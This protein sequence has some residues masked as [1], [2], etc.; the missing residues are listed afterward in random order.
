MHIVRKQFDAYHDGVLTEAETAVY[1]QH[2]STCEECQTWTNVQGGIAHQLRNEASLSKRLSPAATARI[3]Q[4]I[5]RR[6]RRALIMNNIRTFVSAT[7]AIALL[8]IVTGYFIWQ[9]RNLNTVETEV[10]LS[11]DSV[12]VEPP[13]LLTSVPPTVAPTEDTPTNTPLVAEISTEVT[14]TETPLPQPT[15]MRITVKTFED[16]QYG[17]TQIQVLDV[18]QPQ[19]DES[20]PVLFLIQGW[21][22]PDWRMVDSASYYSRQ[23]YNVVIYSRGIGAYPQNEQD[24]FCALAWIHANADTYGFDAERIV[25]IGTLTGGTLAA[26]IATVDDPGI[27][28]GDCPHPLPEGDLIRGVVSVDGF[29]DWSFLSP[30]DSPLVEEIYEYF[31]PSN[32]RLNKMAEASPNTWVDGNEPPF[33]LIHGEDNE[34]VGSEQSEMFAAQLTEAGVN[35]ELLVKSGMIYD[36][37][38]LTTSTKVTIPIKE[39]LT[40]LFAETSAASLP[41]EPIRIR[42]HT[43]VLYNETNNETV[44]V[45]QPQLEDSQLPVPTLFMTASGFYENPQGKIRPMQEY[46]DYFARQGYAVVV[47]NISSSFYYPRFEQDTLCALAWVHANADTYGFDTERIVSISFFGGLAAFSGTVDEPER[48]MEGCPHALPDGDLVS[49]VITI[50]GEFDYSI[51][52]PQAEQLGFEQFYMYFGFPNENLEDIQAA[53]P[54]SWVDGSEPPF[55]LIHAKENLLVDPAQSEMFAALLTEA[56]VAVELIQPDVVVFENLSQESPVNAYLTSTHVRTPIKNF[57]ADLF[58]E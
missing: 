57:L 37:D 38:F 40:N 3:Q 26:F 58:S 39:F 43:N 49:G 33:L 15:R 11:Q 8:A 9:T 25:P 24:T 7:A 18:Y 12:E 17:A 41:R 35:V 42:T 51:Y 16:I 19:M 21:G 1:H 5:S 36:H 47:R 20:L 31:G 45:Y 22:V 44:D 52:V 10:E 14:P 13:E 48:Y 32:E 28:M 2:L 29:F 27:F 23:G 30:G 56:G 6:M 54:I 53:S 55:L 46:A 34:V 50:E 4:H